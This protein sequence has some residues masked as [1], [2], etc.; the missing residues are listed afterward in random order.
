MPERKGESDSDLYLETVWG[1][2]RENF[3]FVSFSSPGQGWL[4]VWKM[5]LFL[6]REYFYININTFI[7]ALLKMQKN[8]IKYQIIGDWLKNY[9]TTV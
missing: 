6:L 5:Q 4:R 9:G 8:G 3:P 2:L 1:N 7:A